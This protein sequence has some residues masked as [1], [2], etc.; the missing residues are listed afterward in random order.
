MPN[1][2]CAVASATTV[3]RVDTSNVVYLLLNLRG[4]AM[5]YRN[6]GSSAGCYGCF[7]HLDGSNVIKISFLLEYSGQITQVIT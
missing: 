1:Y 6:T 5:L 2:T 7:I 3:G 4:N